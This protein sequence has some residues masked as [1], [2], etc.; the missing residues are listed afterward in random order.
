MKAELISSILLEVLL[1]PS[2]KLYN[3]LLDEGLINSE[4]E[5]DSPFTG[6]GYFVLSC[7]GETE[8]PELVRDRIF[9]AL[10]DVE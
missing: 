3:D 9:A 8:Q 2:S 7:G 5:A 1:G 6:D 10:Q 4:F